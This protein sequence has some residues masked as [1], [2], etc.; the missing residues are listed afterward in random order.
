MFINEDTYKELGG[1]VLDLRSFEPCPRIT[2]REFWSSIPED[3]KETIITEAE[4]F[5]GKRYSV[6]HGTDLM[7]FMREGSREPYAKVADIQ[8]NALNHLVLAECIV[9]DGS[10]MDD[11]INAA[12]ALC[13]R[14]SWVSVYHY[15]LYRTPEPTMFPPHDQQALDLGASEHAVALAFT[16]W[17]LK[18]KLDNYS[19]FIARRIKSELKS[20]IIDQFIYSRQLWWMGYMGRSVNNWGPWCSSNCLMTILLVEEDVELRRKAI[21][22]TLEIMER[23]LDGYTE[24][25]GCDEGPAYWTRAG[26]SLYEC[27]WII[28]MATKGELNLLSG[29][30]V[31]QVG[32]FPAKVHIAKT[33]FTN[34]ADAAPYLDIDFTLLYRY[35]KAVNSVNMLDLAFTMYNELGPS[36]PGKLGVLRSLPYLST[37]QDFRK[38]QNVPIRIALDHVFKGIHVLAAREQEDKGKGLF[39]SIKG[40]HNNESHNHNDLGNFI[41]YKNGQPCIIDVGAGVYT[42][43]TFS[44]NRY[45]IWNMQGQ[46]HNVPVIGDYQQVYGENYRSRDFNVQQNAEVSQCSMNLYHAYPKEV[47]LM[48]YTRCAELNRLGST[49]CINDHMTLTT[50]KVITWHFMLQNKPVINEDNIL[51][52]TKSDQVKMVTDFRHLAIDV[53]EIVLDDVNLK[54]HWGD[55]IYRLN[56]K[57][58]E[59]VK[60]IDLKVSF[61]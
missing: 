20:R 11:I 32:E 48:H 9:D 46:Y 35:G 15:S 38:E 52:P 14:S 34:Y 5:V 8:R 3:V 1:K 13:E 37:I 41:L 44:P 39:F 60:A 33:A 22:K 53:D 50:E 12:W 51:L 27:L 43:D 17:L 6:V 19:P 23:F 21:Y 29:N 54:R 58:I 40:G 18:E 26:A 30:I 25:G 56:L 45:K 24:D 42:K 36:S 16:Y 4:Q 61:S 47:G 55:K 28:N 31:K 59:S 7:S 2:E 49:V 10:Y 57:T